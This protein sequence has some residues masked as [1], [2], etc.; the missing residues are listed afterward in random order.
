VLIITSFTDAR[1]VD[2][3]GDASLDFIVMR[4]GIVDPHGVGGVALRKLDVLVA[5]GLGHVYDFLTPRV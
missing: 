5:L 3:R 1:Q 4:R 2:D